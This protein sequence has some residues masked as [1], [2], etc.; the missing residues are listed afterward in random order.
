[1][2]LLSRTKGKSYER[3]VA[4]LFRSR[5]PDVVVRRASQAERA[6][7]PDVFFDNAPD[8][9]QRLWLELTD[10]RSPSPL[11]KLEQAERD[12]EQWLRRRP[13]AIVN[14]M[15][16]VVWHRTGER[17]SH[18]TTRLWVLDDLRDNTSTSME[19]VTVSLAAF[20][21]LLLG[22]AQEERRVA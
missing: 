14:R 20:E 18:V 7:N 13:M 11:A 5:W 21:G 22:A 15:P 8:V 16:V 10:S 19:V 12:I 17:T 2:A 9:L 4:A 3:R 6:D 1:M